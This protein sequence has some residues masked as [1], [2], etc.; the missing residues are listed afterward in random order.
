[1]RWDD[2]EILQAI[3]RGQEQHGG[4]EL[5]TD[6]RLLME[7]I[8]G[9]HVPEPQR[10][11]GFMRELQNLQQAGYL[12]FQFN[13]SFSCPP[14]SDAY[15]WLQQVR[16]FALTTAGQDRARGRV[17]IQPLPDPAEDDGRPI[18]TLILKQ[19]ATAIEN[20]YRADQI[21]VFLGE[22]GIPLDRLPAPGVAED[23]V[24]G[25]LVALDRWGSEGRR[26][27]RILLG[28]W[29]DDQ[30]ISGPDHELRT[31]LLDQ[32]ARQGWY[33]KEDRL[34]IGDR[35]AQRRV[36]S[37]V[38]R[39]AR[40]AALHEDIA[41][42]ADKYLQSGHRTSAVF[43]AMKAVTNRLKQMTGL[44]TD[45]T[46]LVGLALGGERPRVLLADRSTQTGR[47][48]HDGFHA[49]FRGA[50]QAIRNPPAHEPSHDMAENDAFERLNLASLLMRQLDQAVVQPGS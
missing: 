3:D 21:P 28:S 41:T 33:F 9:G 14:A 13:A 19:I 1:M 36:S 48:L 44:D 22:S 20:Q 32:L 24:Y 35:A 47:D 16:N 6:G 40:L 27:L 29:L 5:W 18:S 49:L 25:L 37:P 26:L 15:L 50:V 46:H 2:I 23:D 17:V 43:E 45:G 10:H 8:A 42:V 7:Q 11:R 12:T 31:T 30:L 38:L 4:T 39:D 34:V